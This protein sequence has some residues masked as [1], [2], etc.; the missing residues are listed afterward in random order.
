MFYGASRKPDE[1]IIKPSIAIPL[2]NSGTSLYAALTIFSFLGYVSKQLGIPI[3]EIPTGGE[4]LAF[5]AYPGL[6]TLLKGSN[7]WAIMFFC[8]LFTVGIDSV[9]SMFDFSICYV[10][11]FF[12]TIRQKMRREVYVLIYT[13]TFFLLGLFFVR[14][15]GYWLFTLFNNYAAYQTLLFLLVGEILIVGYYFGLDNLEALMMKRTGE[16]FPFFVKFMVKYVTLALATVIMVTSFINE[17]Q[18]DWSGE[19]GWA[20]FLARLLIFF[21]I[22]FTFVGFFFQI[23]TPTLDDLIMDQY[24]MT[25][26]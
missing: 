6:M 14:E 24:G 16:K 8:M 17:F 7:F 9:F 18:A 11:D 25:M 2:I 21:P 1:K 15:N 19:P 12:P 3:S 20:K 26:E 10:Y 4:D 13:I 22:C 23:N 5:I